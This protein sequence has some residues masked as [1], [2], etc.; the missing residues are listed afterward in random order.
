MLSGPVSNVHNI[1]LMRLSHNLHCERVGKLKRNVHVWAFGT[2]V[3]WRRLDLSHFRRWF[4]ARSGRIADCTWRL[5]NIKVRICGNVSVVGHG[6]R[7]V[8]IDGRIIL[9][10]YWFGRLER[11]SWLFGFVFIFIR[12]IGCRLFDSVFVF[13]AFLRFFAG[14]TISISL[15]VDFGNII[16]GKTRIFCGSWSPV[17]ID[18]CNFLTFLGERCIL[19]IRSGLSSILIRFW[20]GLG[21]LIISVMIRTW[22]ASIFIRLI[23]TW[24]N[25]FWRLVCLRSRRLVHLRRRH[26]DGLCG[27][28]TLKPIGYGALHRIFQYFSKR[29]IVGY[30]SRLL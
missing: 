6:R 4:V 12:S 5:D 1:C 16:F 2:A 18:I 14:R 15:I 25:S 24:R 27:H 17:I 13:K 30:F 26:V 28:N 11:R 19:M 20:L 9:I 3:N 29:V 7:I 22:N 10:W 23:S 8:G 21:D